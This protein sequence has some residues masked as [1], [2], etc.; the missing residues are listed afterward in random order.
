MFR[1]CIGGVCSL[2]KARFQTLTTLNKDLGP[3]AIA[4]GASK[5]IL[6]LLCTFQPVE[7]IMIFSNVRFCLISFFQISM[8]LSEF[9]N[10]RLFK[11]HTSSLS[12]HYPIQYD[13]I[14]YSTFEGSMSMLRVK[15]YRNWYHFETN[16]V[17]WMCSYFLPT[18][19][20]QSVLRRSAVNM[21]P[22][23]T[24]EHAYSTSYCPCDV[25]L[26]VIVVNATGHRS[27]YFEH[28]FGYSERGQANA[29]FRI[30]LQTIW[31][32]IIVCNNRYHM[33]KVLLNACQICLKYDKGKKLIASILYKWEHA[34]KVRNKRLVRVWQRL[35]KPCKARARVHE[36]FSR[37]CILYQSRC[38][39]NFPVSLTDWFASRIRTRAITYGRRHPSCCVHR[40][41]W[42]LLQL[43]K[44]KQPI[45][46]DHMMKMQVKRIA[47]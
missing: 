47:C 34:V 16:G 11:N 4:E 38:Q 43:N 20:H 42:C 30:S 31:F 19:R 15:V 26:V 14:Q 35:K 25:C 13:K 3:I 44:M 37:Y 40:S 41:R 5:E 28:I 17:A 18:Q 12:R 46:S 33:P 24:Q 9:I 23:W 39:Q 1:I 29:T 21:Q 32:T 22:F 45:T 10:R 27:A 36:N 2:T 8:V 6:S 7:R